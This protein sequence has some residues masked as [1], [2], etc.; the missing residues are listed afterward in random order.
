M[1]SQGE[2]H[3]LVVYFSFCM[4]IQPAFLKF[5]KQFDLICIQNQLKCS[6]QLDSFQLGCHLI[7]LF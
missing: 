7:M 3:V 1:W 6:L 2:K 5:L 4:M